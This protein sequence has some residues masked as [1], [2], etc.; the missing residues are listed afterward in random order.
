MT[1]QIYDTKARRFDDR[2]RRVTDLKECARVT[3]PRP[4]D[5]KHEALIEM[6]R[7][8]N[9]RI[10]SEYRKEECNKKG[11]VRG[12]LTEEEKDG[13]K[14]LQKRMKNQEIVILKTDKSGKMCVVTRE[15][16]IRMGQEHTGKDAEI[17]R[18]TIIEKE[19]QLNGHVFFWSKMWGSGEDHNHRDKIIDSKVVSSEQLI[20][21]YIMYISASCSEDTTLLSII[22]SL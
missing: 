4:L 16:Y 6:R 2:K 15:E 19:K 11:D 17:D 10:Y 14:S 20:G 3:L 21:M 12:N 9:E 5:T 18:K 22:L 7:G 13:L 1:R 8:T